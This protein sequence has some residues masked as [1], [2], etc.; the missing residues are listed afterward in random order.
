MPD[1]A[2]TGVATPSLASQSKQTE[3]GSLPNRLGPY[4]APYQET[5]DHNRCR[6][7]INLGPL[8]WPEPQALVVKLPL[9]N[10]AKNWQLF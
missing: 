10:R 4:R 7:D 3:Q 1:H 9:S 8:S 2:I 5:R 6:S